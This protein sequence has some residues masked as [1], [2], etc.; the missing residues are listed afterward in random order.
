M[1]NYT[2]ELGDGLTFVARIAG[3]IMLDSYIMTEDEELI[4]HW[5]TPF[6]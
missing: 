1:A 2:E 3:N 5:F 4:K 6:T